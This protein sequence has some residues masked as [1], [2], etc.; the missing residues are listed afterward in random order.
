MNKLHVDLIHCFIK[1]L[2]GIL[3]NRKLYNVLFY[4]LEI[5]EL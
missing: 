1:N 2:I 3:L 4:Q 5:I